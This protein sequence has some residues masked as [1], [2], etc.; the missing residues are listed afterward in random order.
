L[1]NAKYS[2]VL[3]W[4]QAIDNSGKIGYYMVSVDGGKAK[5]V[6]RTSLKVSKL[7]IGTHSFAVTAY[8]RNKN[9][10]PVS[11]T[12]EFYAADVTAPKK[13]SLKTNVY[14]NFVE[15]SWN[16]VKDNGVTGYADS[17]ELWNMT[18]NVKLDTFQSWEP[19]LY[20]ATLEKGV[21]LF[22]VRAIDAVGNASVSNAKKVTVKTELVPVSLAMNEQEK[23]ASSVGLALGR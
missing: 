11:E 12:L 19:L 21:Y 1:N 15:F 4:N 5:K 17:Y 18:D 3:N 22:Q 10:S 23:S 9:A 8:D 20:G 16:P 7:S 2:A 13:V 14:D 6:S